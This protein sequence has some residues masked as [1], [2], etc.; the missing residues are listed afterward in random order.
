VYFGA[1]LAGA[2]LGPCYPQLNGTCVD[3][4]NPTLIGNDQS[5]THTVILNAI[6]PAGLAG[7]D[8][9]VQA[10][11]PGQIPYKSNV[12]MGTIQPAN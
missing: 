10:G 9:W 7:S 8:V 3:I 12:W 5:A 11:V 6:V 4:L 2:G 1:S